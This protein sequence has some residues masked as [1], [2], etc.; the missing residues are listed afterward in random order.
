MAP[1][2]KRSRKAENAEENVEMDY[3]DVVSDSDADDAAA[4]A[5]LIP[6]STKINL[7]AL[8]RKLNASKQRDSMS[9]LFGE[10]DYSFLSL[11]TDHQHR[12]FWIS[13]DDGHIILEGFSA[14]IEQAQDF[15]TAI[16]EPVSRSVCVLRVLVI[17]ANITQTFAYS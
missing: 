9:Y 15:L 7:T 17:I 2:V 14:I 5:S 8:T 12:P 4:P 1:P 6:R 3:V 16:A 10:Q 11:R 13:P